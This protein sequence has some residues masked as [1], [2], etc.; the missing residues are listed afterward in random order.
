MMA[1]LTATNLLLTGFWSESIATISVLV[2]FL[3][4]TSKLDYN[5]DQESKL[6]LL[7]SVIIIIGS[8]NLAFLIN[9]FNSD[10]NSFSPALWTIAVSI[11]LIGAVII[12]NNYA[13]Q[14]IRNLTINSLINL[15]VM[16]GFAVLMAAE[17]YLNFGTQFIWI[18]IVLLTLRFMLFD[19]D[20]DAF[21]II[22]RIIPGR[23]IYIKLFNNISLTLLAIG[24]IS[25]LYQFWSLN[26]LFGF[27][28]WQ[29]LLALC[30]IA[31]FIFLILFLVEMRRDSISQKI[32]DKKWA[33]EQQVR[34][35]EKLKREKSDSEAAEIKEKQKQ[36]DIAESRKS[37][38]SGSGTIEDYVYIVRLYKKE[39]GLD[40][41]RE[42][43]S[44]PLIDL[45]VISQIKNQII[46][47]QDLS[48]IFE[49]LEK[50]VESSYKDD[51]IRGIMTQI[52]KFF[53][54]LETYKDYEGATRLNDY[55]QA[56]CPTIF[57][58]KAHIKS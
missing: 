34:E 31:F 30:L 57:S 1:V 4:D 41:I 50:I 23:K 37:I 12:L 55:F 53:D 16:L 39:Q 46:W 9:N 29:V 33:D 48:V 43:I 19:Y 21:H 2:I 40:W 8:A 44:I 26:I 17:I 25:T 20:D 49:F 32:K 3:Y 36:Q 18:P 27:K 13:F 5:R 24:L 28:L 35:A 54:V 11:F 22:C 45:V 10:L 6:S 14:K 51:E 52:N 47:G 58:L 56:S 7:N 15:V 42:K 38:E